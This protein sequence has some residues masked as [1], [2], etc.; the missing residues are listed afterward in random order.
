M[1][2]HGMKGEDGQ[3]KRL[4]KRIKTAPLE[5]YFVVKGT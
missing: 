1:K 4:L 5:L 3:L 2:E